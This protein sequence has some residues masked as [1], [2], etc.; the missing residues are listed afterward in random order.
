M[1]FLIYIILIESI[2]YLLHRGILDINDIITNTL[3]FVGG[4]LLYQMIINKS[5]KINLES[6]S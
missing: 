4:I 3:G 1:G 5:K 2:Q 6:Y